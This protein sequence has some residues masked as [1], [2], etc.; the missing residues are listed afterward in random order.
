MDEQAPEITISHEI[1]GG[2]YSNFAVVKHTPYEFT[3]DFARLDYTDAPPSGVVVSRVNLSPLLV[4][5]LMDALE[6][7]WATYAER[8]LPPEAS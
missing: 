2:V 7:N 1:Q 8:A 3:I 5:Q 4:R 6:E